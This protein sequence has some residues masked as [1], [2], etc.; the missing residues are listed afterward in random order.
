MA[1]KN[2][3]FFP[4]ISQ[5]FI[6]QQ[7]LEFHYAEIVQRKI[8]RKFRILVSFCSDFANASWSLN[9][10]IYPFGLI[11][12]D[13]EPATQQL[14][15]F[16]VLLSNMYKINGHLHMW[17]EH[18]APSQI[19]KTSIRHSFTGHKKGQ[20]NFLMLK[21]H[22]TKQ[23]YCS[24]S[25]LHCTYLK[26]YFS[27]CWNLWKSID[28]NTAWHRLTCADSPGSGFPPLCWIKQTLWVGEH[29]Q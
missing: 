4:K 16:S 15:A 26:K 17:L 18:S 14:S 8:P 27:T 11:K 5:N 29:Y 2:S 10:F 9:C 23:G 20:G 22:I 13:K 1:N 21:Y 12:K 24:T 19:K 25:F 6:I 28:M 7:W 3:H